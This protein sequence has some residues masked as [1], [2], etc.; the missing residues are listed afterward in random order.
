MKTLIAG[1]I[2]GTK[3][4]LALFS[5]EKGPHEPLVRLSYPSASYSS[6]DTIVSEFLRHTGAE[7]SLAVFGVAG[8][9]EGSVARITNLSWVIDAGAVS[10]S[11]GIHRIC[12]LNDL[13]AVGYGV[14]LLKEQDLHVLNKGEPVKNGPIA[15]IAPG[16][17]LGEAYLTWDG[18]RYLAH[19]SEG[20]H[21]DFAPRNAREIDLL[22]YLLGHHDH[23]SYE[24]IC[25]G[26]GIPNI[27]RF[28][29][30]KMLL[31]EP[32]WLKEELEHAADP[33]ALIINTAMDT[34]KTCELCR[35]TLRM[36]ISI[37]G[38][39]TGNLA[40]KLLPAGGIFIGGGI[41]PR[42]LDAIGSGGFMDAYLQKGRLAR[43]ISRMPIS[44]I[45]NT[46]VGLIG[47]AGYGMDIL[48][49]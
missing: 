19:A 28:L 20:G 47:S 3:T 39:E 44:V 16:T 30:D 12:L 22:A 38:A 2:G 40:L 23:V 42:I 46:D 48:T 4:N 11:C 6:F 21:T 32:E 17:G 7:V 45:L 13:E 35:E 24:R 1:D 31:Q 18:T 49:T 9:I 43:I 37:L 15:V 41:P 27:Y 34:A 36:F 14:P 25:S 10:S 29:R 5:S 33:T 26:S 8:P